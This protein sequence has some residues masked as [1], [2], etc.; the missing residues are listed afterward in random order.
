MI[1]RSE[2]SSD[3]PFAGDTQTAAGEIRESVVPL[4]SVGEERQLI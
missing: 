4:D 3:W 2:S 1:G